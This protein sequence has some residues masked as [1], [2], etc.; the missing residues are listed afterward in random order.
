VTDSP[1]N[2]RSLKPEVDARIIELCE[3]LLERAKR[4]EFK[5]LIAIYDDGPSC[6]H[7]RAG[8]WNGPKIFWAIETWK[9]RFLHE[10]QGHP[11][12]WEDSN[13]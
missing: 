13:G 10:A 5:A 6:G 12:T 7:D 1:D 8:E 3:A 2:I 11:L 9:H 4:G